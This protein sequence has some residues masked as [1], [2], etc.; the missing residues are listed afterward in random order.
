MVCRVVQAL[1]SSLIIP[2]GAAIV[3]PAFPLPKRGLAVSSWS[4]I[5]A[6]GAAAGPS[7]GGLLIDIG[8]WRWAFWLNLPLG[9]VA[10]TVVAL[11]I[12]E[13]RPTIRCACL[14]P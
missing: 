10:F 14:M 1:G 12:D 13:L 2:S 5:G 4:A 3:F 8:S 11:V 7:L 6:V 9:L